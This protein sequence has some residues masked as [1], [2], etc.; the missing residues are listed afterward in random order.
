MRLRGR[1]RRVTGIGSALTLVALGSAC[2]RT[3]IE[4]PFPPD[5]PY[6]EV[7]RAVRLEG[8]RHTRE[9][10]IRD[11]LQTEVGDVYT[12]ER[13]FDDFNRLMQLG[14]FTQVVFDT[15]PADGGIVLVVRVSEVSKWIPTISWDY[16]E[17]NGWE[18]GPAIAS[19][20]LF[21]RATKLGATARF[22]GAT[23]IGFYFFDPWRATSRWYECCYSGAYF[24]GERRNKLDE[25]EEISDEAD[26]Q[27][28]YSLSDRVHLG[29]RLTYMGVK[30]KPDSAGNTPDVI[31]DPGG[32][33][34]IPGIGAAI[35][36]DSRD[37]AIYPT[38]G[39]YLQADGVQ[40]GGWLGGA[41]DYFRTNLDVRR[42]FRLPWRGHSLS[43]YSLL[44]LTTGE[45]GV[46]IP[47]HQDF[48]IGGTN[49]V[50]GW[51]LGSREGKSQFLN[52]AEYWFM[53]IPRSAYKLGFL[54]FSMG[55]QLAAF[56]DF[57]T[58]WNTSEQ[59]S[60]NWIGGGGLGLRLIIP[61]LV[62]IRFD[63]AAGEPGFGLS[64]HFGTDE[65]ASVQ[66]FRVR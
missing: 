38:T 53:L 41:S 10:V 24:H 5:T 3:P 52:T 34:N 37:Q 31:L 20:N 62:M 43:L 2:S 55:V 15:E 59:F 19:P 16:T 23:N 56:G 64:F 18:I 22:G 39:W 6:G 29:P 54:R 1:L 45:V 17:E 26:F 13:A 11:A 63:L 35:E 66:R 8:H 36:Y 42:F 50:R 14:V 40:H 60:D 47:I 58:A 57:G 32:R 12:T 28:L 27:W 25:F 46:D 48:H 49:T 21:G 9:S 65:K 61:Q 30:A 51:Q 7:V 4:D 44:T 33:D